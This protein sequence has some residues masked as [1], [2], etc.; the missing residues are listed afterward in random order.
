MTTHFATV[1][2]EI[3]RQKAAAEDVERLPPVVLIVDDNPLIIET[4]AAILRG[5]GLAAMTAF[6]GPA[7]LE[8]ADLIPPQMLL[9]DV[10]LGGMNGFELAAEV[11]HRVPDCEVILFSGE[12]ST[13]DVV[14]RHVDGHRFLTL[15]KP[16][17]PR[18]LLARIWEQLGRHGRSAPEDFT[19]LP[20]PEGQVFARLAKASS[21]TNGH[22]PA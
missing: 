22:K 19:L 2:I 1:P 17:H 4:L 5:H 11:T 15:V 16:V 3:A 6:D 8:F 7:A 14:S 21:A 18:Q 10:V 20:N 12:Y 9:S 13:C